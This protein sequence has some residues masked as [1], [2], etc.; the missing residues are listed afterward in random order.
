MKLILSAVAAGVLF[1]GAAFQG[2]S[3]QESRLAPLLSPAELVS[4]QSSEQPLLLD[5]RQG[6]AED[7]RSLYAA[8]HVPG[9]IEAPYAL[10]RGPA[11]DAGRMHDEAQLTS[12]FRS[13]GV[14]TDRPVVVIHQGRDESDFGSAA[15]VYWTLK[16]GGV[17]HLSILN[18]G[19]A[20]WVADGRELST[21]P[22]MPTPSEIDVSIDPTW[23]ATRELVTSVVEGES[24]ATLL[25]SRPEA[26]YRG[27][28]AVPAA[29]R[30]GTLPHAK[31]FTH[32]RWFN[33]SPAIVDGASARRLV[34]EN[35]L[36]NGDTI[37]SFCNTGH[38][39]AT[40]W[41]ALSELGGVEDVKLYPESMV[42][43]S[44]AGLPMEN[45]PGVFQNLWT[46]VKGWF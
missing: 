37:V 45:V 22:T 30:P 12:L 8:G 14:E 29:A 1:A 39:A 28:T 35:G 23:L 34:E 43:W 11:E 17:R 7:G 36:D 18:G 41:F 16:T 38:W 24:N 25:D 33:S 19:V 46:S 15:R 5:I 13:L 20:A 27:E 26:F 32:S 21:E 42:G 44:Q 10:W 4:V 9:S 2:A 40:N 6:Q 31:L 3:A